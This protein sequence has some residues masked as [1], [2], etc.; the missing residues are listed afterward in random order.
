LRNLYIDAGRVAQ[1]LLLIAGAYAI[2]SFM[3]PALRDRALAALLH[4]DPARQA[5]LYSVT[6]G[7]G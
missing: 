6:M 3:T 1:Q 5:P 2:G 7:L 4:L